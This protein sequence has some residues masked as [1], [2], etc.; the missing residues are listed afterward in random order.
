[1]MHGPIY[2]RFEKKITEHKM[3]V[4]IIST[5][6]SELFLFSK[7]NIA[8]FDHKCLLVLRPSTRYSCQYLMKFELSRKIFQKYSN[9]RFHE[10]PSSGSRV[11][12][13]RQT[14]RRTDGRA[15]M[16]KLIV[17]SRNFANAPKSA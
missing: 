9:I 7:S 6:L 15:D 16:N 14:D 13:N 11:V 12:P 1:M 3:C 10:N 5:V 8:R 2:I 4:L 17:A